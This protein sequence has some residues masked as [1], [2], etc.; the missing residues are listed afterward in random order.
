ME[1]LR[2][3]VAQARWQAAEKIAH[4]ALSAHKSEQFGHDYGVLLKEWR[5]LQRA[6]FVIDREGRVTYAEYVPDQMREP[7]YAAAVE[8]ALEAAGI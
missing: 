7:E 4:R 6:V 3:C 2:L 8:A 1:A 5:L